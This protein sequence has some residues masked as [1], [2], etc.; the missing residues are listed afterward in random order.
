[1]TMA[2]LIVDDDPELTDVLAYMLRRAGHDVSVAH[3]GDMALQSAR[4]SSPSLILLD[5]DLPGKNGWDVC[6]EVRSDMNTPVIILSG[7]SGD[8]NVV[9]GLDAGA[10]DYLTKPFSPRQLLA[11]VRAVLRRSE[12]A[13]QPA[14]QSSIIEAGGVCLD[15]QRRKVLVGETEISLTKLEFQLL[16]ELVLQARQVLTSEPEEEA[17]RSFWA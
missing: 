13:G 17:E 12:Q 2:I 4:R 1:M 5:L 9:R 10:D 11:R 3:D 16:F 6:S 8:D 15:V 14:T 7:A